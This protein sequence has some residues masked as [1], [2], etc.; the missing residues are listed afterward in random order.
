MQVEMIFSMGKLIDTT[1][2][3]GITKLSCGIKYF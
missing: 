3:V 2:Y 1:G